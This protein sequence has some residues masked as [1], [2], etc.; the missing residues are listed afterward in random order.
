VR[1]LHD[2]RVQTTV[3]CCGVQLRKP[4][5]RTGGAVL[6]NNV[7]CLCCAVLPLCLQE[8]GLLLYLDRNAYLLMA[9]DDKRALELL[10]THLD[11]LPP[12]G[13]MLTAHSTAYPEILHVM[14]AQ[15]PSDCLCLLP[16][17]H[18]QHG[19]AQY[20]TARGLT[21]HHSVTQQG[22]A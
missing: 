5:V 9:I 12:G 10:A 15:L 3:S 4:A 16:I 6:I 20:G 19:T 2:D 7:L 22:I 14:I 21:A 1:L 18:C 11:T 8:H 17:W 13:A